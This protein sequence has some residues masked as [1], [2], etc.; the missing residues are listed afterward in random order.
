MDIIDKEFYT[1]EIEL[2]KVEALINFSDGLF[3]KNKHSK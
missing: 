3:P 1:Y 2:G